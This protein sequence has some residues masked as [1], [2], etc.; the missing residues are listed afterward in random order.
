MK[1]FK[2]PSRITIT[3]FLLAV[4]IG[5]AWYFLQS[6]A[7]NEIAEPSVQ[8]AK[9][10]TGDL[11]L[12]AIGAGT[13]VP[14]AQVD[15]SFQTNGVL[16]AI[17][18]AVGDAVTAGQVLG[19]LEENAQ[20]EADFQALFSPQGLAQAELAVSDAEIVL[21]AAENDW[22]NLIG[23]E[24]WYW[25][26]QLA[27][28][29]AELDALLQNPSAPSE[30]IADAQSRV[31][32]AQGWLIYWQQ[33]HTDELETT[34]KVIDFKTKKVTKFHYVYYE[35]TDQ[36]LMTACTALELARVSLLDAQSALEIVQA[37]PEALTAPLAALGP[38]MARIEKARQAVERT[39]LVAPF[40]G[41]VTSLNGTLGQNVG[42]SPVV[43]LSTDQLM[44]RFY[45]DESDL[46]KAMVGNP[47]IVTAEAY[48][49]LPLD[50]R[51]V[52]VEP[53]LQTVDGS[54]AV[55]VWA[56]LAEGTE[57]ALLSGMSVE[58]ESIA[59]EARDALLVPIQS[60]HL[61]GPDSYAVNLVLPNGSL[62]L[63]PVIVGLRDYANAVILSGLK[64][65]DVVS[66]AP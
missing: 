37:G 14:A 5:G 52:M 20:T 9:V 43:T 65:G 47:V 15:L 63:T 60:L 66:T 10:R 42:S 49:D 34:Y 21:T 19:R 51:I 24:A 16:A 44:V 28:A 2:E 1:F 22:I 17:D 48:P 7:A 35:V 4:V 62:E 11:V 50:G 31:D 39:R 46:T 45:L 27:Q 40:D 59:G 41:T 58:V 36:E 26:G 13:I 12:S 29:Q 64:V 25:E 32:V 61:V 23:E 3:F 6:P 57:S 53:T 55:V 54:P 18:V 56:A 38:Q 8:T 33:L 30:Q